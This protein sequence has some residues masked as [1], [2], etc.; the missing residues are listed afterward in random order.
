MLGRAA[1]SALHIGLGAAILLEVWRGVTLKAEVRRRTDRVAGATDGCLPHDRLQ[2]SR[3]ALRSVPWRALLSIGAACSVPIIRASTM[4]CRELKA[5][6]T[7]ARDFEAY[8]LQ[9]HVSP[10]ACLCSPLPTSASKLATASFADEAATRS[11]RCCAALPTDG[12]ASPL[13]LVAASVRASASS[14]HRRRASAASA[15]V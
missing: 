14:R 11:S 15:G 7:Q 13:P 12:K 2:I 5:Q 3:Q 6:T 10:Q 1:R 9:K 4:P 8:C